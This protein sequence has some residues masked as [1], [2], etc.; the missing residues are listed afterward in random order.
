MDVLN[1]L[2]IKGLSIRWDEVPEDSYVRETV[3]VRSVDSVRFS[4]PVTFFA[5]E[6]GS[7]K[8]T[9][10]EAMAVAYGFNAEGGSLNYD[11]VTYSTHSELYGCLILVKGYRRAV[12]GYYLR[13]ESFYNV[14]TKALDYDPSDRLHMQS[15][16]ESFMSIMGGFRQNGLFFLDEPEAALSPQMQLSLLVR[17]RRLAESGSQFF[18]ATHS[19]ILLGLPGASILSF[20]DGRI[21]PVEYEETGSYRITRAFVSGRDKMLKYLLE[22]EN[23][24]KE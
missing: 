13:A 19:P 10:L 8:S 4:S 16:G 18:I 3:S 12:T 7:G 20:D 21:R 5:G 17:I 23:G 1:P 9:L 24:E 11:F 2:F 22:A 6:N 15:H 14:A